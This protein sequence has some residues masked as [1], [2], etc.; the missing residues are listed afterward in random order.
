MANSYQFQLIDPAIAPGLA[1]YDDDSREW[2][3]E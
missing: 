1:K 2:F 3:W